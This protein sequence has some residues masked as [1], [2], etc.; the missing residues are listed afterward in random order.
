MK[1]CDRWFTEP[2]PPLSAVQVGQLLSEREA[3]LKGKLLP[4]LG[5]TGAERWVESER[6]I[7]AHNT[8]D[9]L[10]GRLG[11]EQ[12]SGEQSERLLKLVKA[13]PCELTIGISGFFDFALLGTP[14]DIASHLEQV[15]ASN[16]RVLDQAGS[17]LTPEQF[18]ALTAVLSNG[19]T[20]RST[21]AAALIPKRSNPR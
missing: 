12:L 7:P 11:S 17:F 19:I 18:T 21:Q 1:D 14:E 2:V 10:N 15:K 6:E 4:L 9:L 13:Q 20:W 8:V 16:Q 5:A 3:E